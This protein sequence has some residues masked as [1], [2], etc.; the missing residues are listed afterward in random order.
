MAGFA[1]QASPPQP[2][3]RHLT[4]LLSSNQTHLPSLQNIIAFALS[5]VNCTCLVLFMSNLFK[6]HDG[7]E[8]GRWINMISDKFLFNL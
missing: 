8:V 6:M 2:P 4:P 1:T 3:Y 7:C 5:C